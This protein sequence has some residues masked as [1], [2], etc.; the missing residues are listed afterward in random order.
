MNPKFLDFITY[1]NIVSESSRNQCKFDDFTSITFKSYNEKMLFNS[2]SDHRENTGTIE[3]SP[4]LALFQL[5]G[6]LCIYK[7][8]LKGIALIFN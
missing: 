8:P 2:L 1:R 4:L 7:F 5:I 6:V 3:I